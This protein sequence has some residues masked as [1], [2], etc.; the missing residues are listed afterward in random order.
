M[1]APPRTILSRSRYESGIGFLSGAAFLLRLPNATETNAPASM[2]PTT[3]FG[4]TNVSPADE[5]YE[6]AEEHFGWAETAKSERE[7]AIFQQ[8]R[9]LGLK[10]RRNG[11]GPG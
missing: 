1:A 5:F 4:A 3:L 2:R 7:R 9:P 6:N 11:T 10:S 8:W